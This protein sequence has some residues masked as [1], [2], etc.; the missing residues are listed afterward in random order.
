M[1]VEFGIVYAS[2]HL[3]NIGHFS[4][5]CL[6]ISGMR[7]FCLV[8]CSALEFIN[9]YKIG[10]HVK[11]CECLSKKIKL[12]I[13]AT[14]D[15]FYSFDGY[16]APFHMLSTEHRTLNSKY[17]YVVKAHGS[18]D[19]EYVTYLSGHENHNIFSIEG[20]KILLFSVDPFI[21]SKM[22]FFP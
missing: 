17:I 15:L 1:F 2:A 19:L 12:F 20:K 5:Y 8:I 13:F 16:Q 18:I 9:K 3:Q 7:N 14:I 4:Y 10:W 21:H 6:L 22:D 11:H